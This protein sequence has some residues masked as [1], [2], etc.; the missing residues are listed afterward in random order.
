MRAGSVRHAALG[1]VRR[2]ALGANRT[3]R[4]SN[5]QPVTTLP[6][7]QTRTVVKCRR[8]YYRLEKGTNCRVVLRTYRGMRRSRS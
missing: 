8:D 5:I 7:C 3:D 4:L 1:L 2:L 6:V